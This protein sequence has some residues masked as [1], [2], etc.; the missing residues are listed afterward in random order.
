MCDFELPSWHALAGVRPGSREPE[1]FEPGVLR[2]GWQHEATSRIELHFRDSDFRSQGGPGAG[3]AMSTCPT[4]RL[5]KIPPHLFRLVLLRRLGL[6]LPLTARSCRCGR[7]LHSRGRHGEA[8]VRAGVLEGRGWAMESAVA[9]G[10]REAGGRGTTNVMVR[11]L[12][13]IQSGV[14][15]A[16][17]LEMVVDGLPHFGGAQL[18]SGCHSRQRPLV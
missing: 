12:D 3:S 5:T 13:L 9:R 18:C 8:C 16:R 15:D 14:I 2:D 7:P 17:R 11:D 4:S 10:C 6:P 1:D